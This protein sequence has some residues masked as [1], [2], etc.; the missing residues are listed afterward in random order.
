M[1]GQG[2]KPTYTWWQ[3]PPSQTGKD[4]VSENSRVQ[5]RGTFSQAAGTKEKGRGLGGGSVPQELSPAPRKRP[6]P[7]GDP[8]SLLGLGSVPPAPWDRTCSQGCRTCAEVPWLG[9]PAACRPAWWCRG[10]APNPWHSVQRSL[11]PSC[12]LPRPLASTLGL[13]SRPTMAWLLLVA[14]VFGSFSPHSQGHLSS[15]DETDH[16]CVPVISLCP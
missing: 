12:G 5:G 9:D 15:W 6:L 14:L 13:W 7:E 1:Q 8:G 11:C 4:F 16:S 3:T 2:R 10:S